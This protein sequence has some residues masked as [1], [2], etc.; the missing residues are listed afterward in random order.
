MVD[1]RAVEWVRMLADQ[2]GWW[3]PTKADWTDW[4]S[5]G[6]WGNNWA[7]RTAVQ[8]VHNSVENLA[9]HW[10]LSTAEMKAEWT[11]PSS[12]G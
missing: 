9:G 8:W 12:V 10:E 6:V 2:S 4:Y 1:L 5:A 11:A 7:E 3:V